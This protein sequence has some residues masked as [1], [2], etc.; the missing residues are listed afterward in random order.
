MKYLVESINSVSVV[1]LWF[2]NDDINIVPNV[3]E[4]LVTRLILLTQTAQGLLIF[5]GM[6]EMFYFEQYLMK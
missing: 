6:Y 2:N 4:K 3:I 1:I 5:N